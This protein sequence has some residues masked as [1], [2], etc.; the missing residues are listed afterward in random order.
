MNAETAVIQPWEELDLTEEEFNAHLQTAVAYQQTKKTNPLLVHEPLPWQKKMHGKGLPKSIRAA[1]GGNQV[2]KTTLSCFEMIVHMTQM[3]PEWWPLECR[4]DGLD[5]RPGPPMEAIQVGPDFDN[6]L[7]KVYLPKFQSLLP[8]G[9]AEEVK[10]QG[11]IRG[12]RFQYLN[13][14]TG[15]VEK[16][17]RNV[18]SFMSY[19]QDTFAFEGNTIDIAGFDEPP[20][21]RIWSATKRGL[22]KRDGISLFSLTPLTEPWIDSEVSGKEDSDPNI[23]TTRVEIWENCIENGGYLRRDQIE[24]FLRGLPEDERLAR[25]KGISRHLAGQVY[26]EICDDHKVDDFPIHHDWTRYEAIDPHGARPTCVLFCAVDRDDRRYY[27]DRLVVEG[28]PNQIYQAVMETRAKHGGQQPR[29]TLLDRKAA[30]QESNLGDEKTSWKRELRK[31]GFEKIQLSDSSPG[32]VGIGA[33]LVKQGLKLRYDHF[34]RKELPDI[35]FFK[36]ACGAIT[37]DRRGASYGV[38]YQMRSVQWDEMMRKSI[39]EKSS[40]D[41]MKDVNKDFPDLVRYIEQKL[42]KQG[43]KYF[44]PADRN[45]E[46]EE[47]E[48]VV[49]TATGYG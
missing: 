49:T 3:Y 47:Q 12:Y 30:E 41:K 31:A 13:R 37:K 14:R 48:R 46:E 16:W 10:S 21:Y 11:K 43:R 38:L 29:W 28:S 32:A 26:P 6:W 2:G 7:E 42:S 22:M 8:E 24:D 36:K 33:R 15:E 34:Q 39:H 23:Y 18:V 25:E 44:D 27:Y 17:S 40:V 4:R 5:G 35:F 45:D 1:F 20:P 19:L 9:V